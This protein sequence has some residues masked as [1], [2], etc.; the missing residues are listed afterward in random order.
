M[1]RLWLAAV[2]ISI[3][4]FSCASQK[5]KTETAPP[6]QNSMSAPAAPESSAQS[7]AANVKAHPA[8]AMAST[9]PAAAPQP[10]DVPAPKINPK[11]GKPNARFM[12]MHE[13]FVQEAKKDDIDLLFLGDSITEGWLTRGKSV[14][15]KRYVDKY[16]V[17]N[18]G[19]GGDRT[20]HVLWRIENGELEGIHPKVVVLMIGTNN[21]ASN[22][23]AQIA[24]GVKKIVHDIRD[25]TGA[26]VLLLG[27][28]PR[29]ANNDDP[30][31]KVDAEVNQ[32]IKKLDDGTNVR[33]LEI[34]DQFLE[35]DGTLTREMMPDLLHPHE[36]GYTI[37]ADAMQPLLNEMM[38][39]TSSGG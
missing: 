5:H 11:T 6:P 14:W 19:I 15:Q 21:A 2:V 23:P 10:A 17:A 1:K 9:R 12:Q 8:I 22:P 27:V 36:K 29:G 20:Q 26:K 32:I 34:W 33:Y 3:G 31:R 38:G 24:D 13:K 4:A 25:K 37:W 39:G 7:P 18:F 35:P 28:F 30:K 16:K